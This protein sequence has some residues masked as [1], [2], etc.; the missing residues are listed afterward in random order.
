LAGETVAVGVVVVVVVGDGL[1]VLI[2]EVLGVLE[3]EEKEDK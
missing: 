1:W 2:E 3:E